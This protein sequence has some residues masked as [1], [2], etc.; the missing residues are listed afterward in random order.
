L[1]NFLGILVNTELHLRFTTSDSSLLNE[2]Q[3]SKKVCKQ[4]ELESSFGYLSHAASV[5]RSGH[6]FLQELFNHFHH[7]QSHDH[8]RLNTKALADIARFSYSNAWTQVS[9]MTVSC[10][11]PAKMQSKKKAMVQT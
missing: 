5:V 2:A 3:S 10:G 11:Q 9:R 4:Q 7:T 8:I 1:F 6:T